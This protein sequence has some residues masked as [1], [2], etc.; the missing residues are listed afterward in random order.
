MLLA[1]IYIPLSAQTDSI[2]H[3]QASQTTESVAFRVPDKSKIEKYRNDSRFNYEEKV[4][5]TGSISFFDKILRWISDLFGDGVGTFTS[6]GIPGMLVVVVII[7]VICI[8]VL[9]LLGVDYRT[10]FGKKTLDTAEIDIY[11][12]NVHE[13]DFDSLIAN[14]IQNKDFRL[15]IRF[16][17]LKNLKVLSDRE[18][19]KWNANK[20]NYS[21]QYEIKNNDL[22]SRFLETTLIFD[23]IWYGEFP[24]EEQGFADIRTRM[25]D[26]NRMIANGK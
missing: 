22:R 17:Y 6:S 26:F 12:E 15:A 5:K 2:A 4:R 13:M 24:V 1:C 9:K 14:A 8:I 16:L 7:I 10:I 23:Y 19:I 25:N 18:I 3:V 11:T 21:Y 20:T